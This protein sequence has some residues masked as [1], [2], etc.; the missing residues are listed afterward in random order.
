MYKKKALFLVFAVIF[1]GTVSFASAAQDDSRYFVKSTS[2]FWKKSFGYRNS[3]D[4]G[5]SASLSDWQLRLAKIFGIDVEPVTKL[6][7]LPDASDASNKGKISDKGQKLPAD[8]ISWGLKLIYNDPLLSETSGGKDINVAVLDTGVQKAHPD[9][10]SRVKDCKDFSSPSSPLIDGK[11]D[12]K[13]GHGTHIAGIVAADGG[14]DKVGIYGIAPES[15][16]VVFKV[17]SNNGICFSDDVAAGIYK[18][19]DSGT[20]IINLS[21]GSDLP[22]QLILNAVKYAQANSV[23]V[24]AAAGNDGPYIGSIDYPAAFEEVVGVG[25]ININLEAPDWSARG[26]NSKTEAYKNEP[27]DIEFAAPGVNIESTWKDGGYAVFSGT[28]MAAPHLAGL[29]AKFWQKDAENPA[30]ETREVLRKLSQD[31]L[32]KG[33][34]DASG[35][36]LPK[37]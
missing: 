29:A 28:S 9:L 20:Q 36:G 33:D 23:L 22:S 10:Q 2:S 11:C 5:F 13:N 12:D 6:N 3:F 34:D 30:R 15:N 8:Q 24:I 19:V 14:K 17:C 25:A 26:N 35:W 7:I 4:D 32:P 1:F 37:L 16:L 27:G 21:L 18:A 31:I